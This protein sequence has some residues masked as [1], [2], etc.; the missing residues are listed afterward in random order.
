[1][2]NRTV[3]VSQIHVLT[4]SGTGTVSIVLTETN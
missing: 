2:A 3:K 4:T 1:M